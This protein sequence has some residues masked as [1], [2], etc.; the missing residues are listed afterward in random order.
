[1]KTLYISKEKLIKSDISAW[2]KELNQV[3]EAIEELNA[4]LPTIEAQA[5]EWL[6]KCNNGKNYEIVEA[7][8]VMSKN[9]S[10]MVKDTERKIADLT[11]RAN[12]INGLIENLKAQL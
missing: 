3:N 5:A 1:M 4:L 8:V 6:Y 12:R 2:K 11:G 7:Y 9:Y 10:T